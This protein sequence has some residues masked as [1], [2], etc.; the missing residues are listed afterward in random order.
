VLR[1][2]VTLI[3]RAIHH[4]RVLPHGFLSDFSSRPDRP[5]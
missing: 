4:D 5:D 2:Y 3:G 1:D